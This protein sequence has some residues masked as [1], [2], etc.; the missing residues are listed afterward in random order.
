MICYAECRRLCKS[1]LHWNHMVFGQELHERRNCSYH[2]SLSIA[3]PF[4]V[5]IDPHAVSHV[6]C[7]ECRCWVNSL[8]HRNHMVFGPELVKRRNCSY[9]R[10]LS[11]ETPFVEYRSAVRWV[12]IAHAVSHVCYAECRCSCKSLLHWNHMVFGQELHE[13]RYCSYHRSLSIDPP[14]IEYD[15]STLVLVLRV[16]AVCTV[17]YC[18][19]HRSFVEY[20]RNSEDCINLWNLKLKAPQLIHPQ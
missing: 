13:R 16:A 18:S 14:F 6:C 10:S 7:A 12:S 20:D 15:R 11:I 1:L 3:P 9:H 19:Y 2:R 4:V 5:S 8:L 17:R